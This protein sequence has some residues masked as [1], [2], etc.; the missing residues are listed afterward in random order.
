MSIV[1]TF[2]D[3]SGES[4]RYHGV[5][6]NKDTLKKEYYKRIKILMKHGS[7]KEDI[8]K[9]EYRRNIET[10]TIFKIEPHKYSKYMLLKPVDGILEY[11]IDFSDCFDGETSNDGYRMQ[12]GDF[13]MI[14]F[15][16]CQILANGELEVIFSYMKKNKFICTCPD[17]PMQS[18]L[19]SE[20]EELYPDIDIMKIYKQYRKNL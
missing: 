18:I 8:R 13:L 4:W 16:D 17:G 12:Q 2:E 11:D 20:F 3:N 7:E 15:N 19:S 1:A 5:F 6:N 14:R 10:E 9:C